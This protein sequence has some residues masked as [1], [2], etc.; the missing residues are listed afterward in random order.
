ML[1]KINPTTTQAWEKL[2]SHFKDIGEKHLREFFAED[3]N[4]FESFS[5]QQGD[6]F[7]DFSKNRINETTLDLLIELAEEVDLRSGID[8]MFSGD[9]INETESRAVL[10][11]A[12]RKDN[13]DGVIVGET[14]TY[15]VVQ[16][17]LA[18]MKDYVDR[19]HNGDLVGYTGRKLRHVV[20]IG[21]G[22]SDL[23]PYM[24]SEAL[25]PYHKKD[26]S[27]HFI[28]NVDG[29]DIHE[30]LKKIDPET[31]LFIVASKSFTTQETMTNAETAR[32][33]IQSHGASNEDLSKHFIALSTNIEKASAFGVA[34]ENIFGFWSWVGGR[35]SLSSAIGISIALAVGFDRFQELRAG[36]NQIDEHFKKAPFAENIPAIMGLLGIWY[37][38]FFEAESHAILPYDQYLHRFPAYLQQA[39]M[40]SNGKSIDRAGHQVGYETGPVIWGEPGTNGQHAFYQLIHQGSKLIPCDF[41]ASANAHHDLLDHH[42]KLLANF[43]AQTEALMNGKTL[44]EVVSEAKESG[45]STEEI[46]RLAPYKVF[47]G[48]R[49]T[50][51]FLL[52]ELTPYTLGQLIALYE[53]KIFVQGYIWNVFSFDQ[54]GVQL[55]KQ[56]A[57]EILPELKDESTPGN[58]DSS[59]EGLIKKYHSYKK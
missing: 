51:S 49:P 58:H 6:L 38:N 20:N 35:Y 30:T 36:L 32:A 12:L 42:E 10:H 39:D 5:R 27:L 43:L 47:D 17:I 29:A 52:K 24:V 8:A 16:E 11:T 19:F 56:L 22:G 25:T 7:F 3:R 1:K 46:E 34:E 45:M 14:D 44:D 33:W 26:V 57:V 2:E 50:N 23:G 54:W 40:E 59:T 37:N 13:D 18:R 28:S 48:N 41:I 4:R 31:T 53:H 21:I 15:A 9:K 55:G